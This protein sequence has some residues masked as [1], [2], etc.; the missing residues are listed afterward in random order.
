[1]TDMVRKNGRIW[2]G[3]TLIELLVVIA[4]IAILL[5][6]LLPAVQHA[7]EAARRTQCRN[8][9]AQV[10]LALHNYEMA[11]EFLPPGTVDESGPIQNVAEGYHVSWIVQILPM[12]DQ[13]GVFSGFDFDDGAYA[14]SN[15]KAQGMQLQVFSCPSDYAF[16]YKGPSGRSVNASSYAG[17]FAGQDVAI[18][19]EGSGVLFLN[20]SVSYDQIR[21]GLSSTI[22]V[23]EKVNPRS[24][25][26]L[27]WVSGT[28]ATLRNTG[29]PINKGWDIAAYFNPRLAKVKN[30]PNETATGGYS[31]QHTGGAQFLLCDGSVRFINAMI[32]SEVLGYLGDRRDLNAVERF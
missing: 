30:A 17:C 28:S 8:N 7:R 5:S 24:T 20:S 15:A 18:D 27:G 12:V 16:Q 11:F 19:S 31:S 1:M 14:A 32:S 10:G 3:F 21:D 2:R 22:M 6:L 29:V 23:G 25:P 4:I 26:D 9:L 13:V